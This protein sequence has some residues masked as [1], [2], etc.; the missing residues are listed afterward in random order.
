[1][2]RSRGYAAFSYADLEKMVGIRK[3]SIHH[4]FPKKEDLGVEIVETY[5]NRSAVDFEKIDHVSMINIYSGIN[6]CFHK[7]RVSATEQRILVR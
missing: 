2:L 3:A 4:Y 5:I 1:M 7:L 6:H